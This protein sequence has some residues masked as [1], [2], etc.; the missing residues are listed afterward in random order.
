M[1]LPRA[2]NMLQADAAD[3]RPK[4]NPSPKAMPMSPSAW[5]VAPAG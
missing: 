5:T 3:S 1:A 2:A 4:M